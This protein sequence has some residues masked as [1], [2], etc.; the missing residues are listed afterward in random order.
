MQGKL[1]EPVK[2]GTISRCADILL[3]FPKA[4]DTLGS[5]AAHSS[6]ADPEKLMK[7][8]AIF[9]VLALPFLASAT[10]AHAQQK[11]EW[12]IKEFGKNPIPVAEVESYLN[13]SCQT[14]GLDGIQLLGV[15]NGHNQALHLHVYCRPDKA[16]KVQYKV[17]LVPIPD[18]NPDKAVTPFLGDPVVRVGP[19]YFGND[20]EPDGVLIVQIA[21]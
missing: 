2:T 1:P 16:A 15:Q 7:K 21:K 13:E 4:T 11:A 19:F 12:I 18:R 20:G 8:F 6:K 14:S 10:A 9:L 17:L 5:T 3:C